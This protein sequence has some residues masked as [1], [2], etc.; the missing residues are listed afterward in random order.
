MWVISERE[1]RLL[2]PAHDMQ[3]PAGA[4]DPGLYAR[5]LNP[6]APGQQSYEVQ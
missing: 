3:G 6:V 5:Y 2:T 1:R 4:L